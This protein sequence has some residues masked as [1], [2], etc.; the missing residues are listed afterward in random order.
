MATLSVL[1]KVKLKSC[2]QH[3]GAQVS[4][5][6]RGPFSTVA[7]C[8]ICAEGHTHVSVTSHSELAVKYR[9]HLPLPKASSC[10][11]L[12]WLHYKRTSVKHFTVTPWWRR[13]AL[14]APA[15]CPGLS[16][17]G[18]SVSL[19]GGHP[20]GA[21]VRADRHCLL[22]LCQISTISLAIAS[23]FDHCTWLIKHLLESSSWAL[24]RRPGGFKNP[25]SGS[26]SFECDFFPLAVSRWFEKWGY[27]GKCPRVWWKLGERSYFRADPWGFVCNE[28]QTHERGSLL[29]RWPFALP[30]LPSRRAIHVVTYSVYSWQSV[31]PL[32]K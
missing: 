12:D 5:H 16:E 1:H 18:G 22:V 26:R 10:F 8:G 7:R 24:Y 19:L 28:D 4:S 29:P 21:E 30:V 3:R 9:F 20:S 27:R 6:C 32:K 15:L 14:K 17:R 11:I 31:I 13:F 2:I 23:R 25:T